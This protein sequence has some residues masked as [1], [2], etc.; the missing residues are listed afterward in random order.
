MVIFDIDGVLADTNFRV[1]KYLK[2]KNKDDI[3]W[4]SFFQDSINDLPIPSGILTAKAIIDYLP[5]SEVMFLTSRPERFRD[6]TLQWLSENLGVVK[7]EVDLTMRPDGNYEPA[8]VFKEKVG[9]GL[10]FKNIDLAFD[11]CSDTVDMWRKHNVICYQTAKW[12]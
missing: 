1:K 4:D 11:D 3:D 2:G 10:G 9:E 8:V 7:S 5:Q 6:I 12:E